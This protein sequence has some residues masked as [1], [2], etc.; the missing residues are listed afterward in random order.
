MIELSDISFSYA[1]EPLLSNVN[2]RIGPRDFVGLVGANGSGK[3]TLVKLVLGLLKP[4]AGSVRYMLGGKAVSSIAIGYL[5][6]VSRI[7]PLFPL[8]VRA[9]VELGLVTGKSLF[10]KAGDSAAVDEALLRVGILHLDNKP[11]GQLSGGELQ[12]TLL[13]R[14]IVSRPQMLILDEPDTFLDKKSQDTLYS[15]LSELNRECAVLVV[16][17]NEQR[18]KD[19]ASHIAYIDGT[20]DCCRIEEGINNGRTE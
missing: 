9:V 5:P 16:S 12:R 10:M 15:L 13:A 2:M 7:D 3:T 6:Q 8:T 14:A 17:H 19:Y 18:I 4:S 11:I 20:V 1:G